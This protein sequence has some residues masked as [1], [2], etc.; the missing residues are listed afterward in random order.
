MWSLLL[1]AICVLTLNNVNRPPC[2]A[3]KE[4][5]G[6]VAGSGVIQLDKVCRFCGRVS[7]VQ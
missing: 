3:I 7:V 1:L 4:G 2:N 5:V 6:V